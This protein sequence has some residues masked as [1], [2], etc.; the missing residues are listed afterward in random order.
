[1]FDSTILE[2]IKSNPE[3]GMTELIN[4]YT[5]LVYTIISN[6]ISGI[7]TKEDIEEAVSDVFTAFYCK[8]KEIDLSK[9]TISAYLASIAKHKATDRLRNCSRRCELFSEDADFIEI[10]DSYNLESETEKKVLYAEL[11][12]N[13]K[14]LGE[15]DSTIIFRRYFLGETTKAIGEHIQ[16]HDDN[17]R[18][19]L[20]RALKK[21]QTTMK[22]AYYYEN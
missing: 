9:G 5:G 10:P 15:P 8:A 19:H 7:C 11:I 17:V 12:K 18:K 4:Q 16:M 20:S 2:L 3:R 22:G 1:M 21:L 13:I 6:K 14:A